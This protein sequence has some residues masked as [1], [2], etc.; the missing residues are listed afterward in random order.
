ML[1]ISTLSRKGAN[2]CL[3]FKQQ[4]FSNFKY[5]NER[6]SGNTNLKDKPRLEYVLFCFSVRQNYS[7]KFLAVLF[8]YFDIDAHKDVRIL[9]F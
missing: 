3:I 4:I 5:P 7:G 1:S 9:A 6:R 2:S 8:V